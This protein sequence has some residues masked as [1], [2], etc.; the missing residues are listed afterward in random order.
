MFYF[1]YLQFILQINRKLK[2]HGFTIF[3]IKIATE[4]VTLAYHR[5]VR[6]IKVNTLPLQ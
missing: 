5:K 1:I 4:S 3:K 6:V 2:L